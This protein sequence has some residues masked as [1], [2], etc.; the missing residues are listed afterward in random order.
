MGKYKVNLSRLDA[1]ETVWFERELESID[2]TDYE[3]LLPGMLG[4][5]YIPDIQN[6]DEWANVYTYRMYEKKGRAKVGSRNSDDAPRVTLIGKETSKTIK[7][8]QSSYGWTVGEIQR[9]AGTGRPL[10]NMTVLAARS[11]SDR[12]I[13]D[14]LA[15]GN[16]DLGIEGLYNLTG[17]PSPLSAVA[18]TSGTT[19]AANA[20]TDAAKILADINATTTD[21]FSDLKQTDAPGFDKFVMLVPTEAYAAIATTPRS[22]TSDTT[23]LQ[24]ALANNPWLESIEPWFKG[25]GAGAG[26][27]N[28]VVVYPRTP[29]CLGA[30]VPM[31][32]TTLNPQERNFE[33]IVPARASCGGV[34][35]RYPIA[36]R[37]LDGV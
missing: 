25:D 18:K 32:F 14:L 35:C 10:D 34:V 5:R 17:V 4:R 23:I 3:E 29:L 12:E 28:R 15:S 21:L 11:A 20:A 36:V 7:E 33:V 24:F 19:W 8:I 2:D 13:D 30:L 27:T 6:V 16:T 31:D 1:A 22:T 26:A 37:Y 9:A